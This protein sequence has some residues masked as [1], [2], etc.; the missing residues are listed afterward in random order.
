MAI[1]RLARSLL[2][3]AVMLAVGT[4]C[5]GNPTPAPSAPASAS[6]SPHPVAT[7]PTMAVDL[8]DKAWTDG[9]RAAAA[10]VAQ[11][12]ALSNLFDV[13]PKGWGPPRFA[14]GVFRLRKHGVPGFMEWMVQSVGTGFVVN[15]VDIPPIPLAV[16]HLP[17]PVWGLYLAAG[18]SGYSQLAAAT[19]ELQNLGMTTA[20]IA[21]L[22]ASCQPPA[23]D[24]LQ[25][26]SS[27]TT[28]AVFFRSKSEAETFE[29]EL[30]FPPIGVVRVSVGC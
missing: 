7:T 29:A 20:T 11:E 1:D 26:P 4:S 15:V 27:F 3:I 13:S 14:S 18:G 12:E 21:Q 8:L 23:A 22:P 30:D 2:G 6:P 17:K 16:A 19:A 9:D 10:E 25:I 24:R 5:T 28:I